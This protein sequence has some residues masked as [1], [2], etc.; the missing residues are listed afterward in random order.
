MRGERTLDGA[1]PTG[2]SAR[3]EGEASPGVRRSRRWINR[4]RDPDR[5]T[6]IDRNPIDLSYIDAIGS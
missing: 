3:R 1:R 6:K 4:E 5:V 2:Q